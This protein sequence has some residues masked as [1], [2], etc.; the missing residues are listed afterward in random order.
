MTN[1]SKYA[2]KAAFDIMQRLNADAQASNTSVKQSASEI[3]ARINTGSE[4]QDVP[5]RYVNGVKVYDGDSSTPAGSDDEQRWVGGNTPE[6]RT[7]ADGVMNTGSAQPLSIEARDR[8]AELMETGNY[9]NQGDGSKGVWGRD[10]INWVD[11]DGGTISQQLLRE[12]YS[13]PMVG[14]DSKGRGWDNEKAYAESLSEF[15]AVGSTKAMR[16]QRYDYGVIT[17]DPDMEMWD[18]RGFAERAWDRGIDHTQMNLFQ[19]S[20]LMGE[21]TG[22][23]MMTEWGEEG[24]IRNMHEAAMSPA[25]VA[26]SDDIE[27]LTD[28][29]KFI[30]EKTIENAP[31]LLVDLGVGAAS[32]AAVV[33]TGGAASAVLAPALLASI[34]KS[35]IGKIGWKA[36]GKFGVQSAMF[37][38]MAGEARHGQLAEGVDNPMLAL[39][40]GAVNTTLEF[41]GMQSMLQGFMP[42]GKITNAASLAKHIAQRAAIS[43]GVEG[44]TE[45]LQDLNN[46]IAIKLSKPDYTI[47]WKQL[48]ESFFAGMAAGGGMGTV[49]GTAG[50]SYGL[51]KTI[52]ENVQTRRAMDGTTPEAPVQIQAQLANITDPNTSLDAVYAADPE[53]ADKVTLPE[54]VIAYNHESGVLFTTNEAKGK[55]FEQDGNKDAKATLGYLETKEEVMANTKVEDLRSVVA[56]DVDG[57]AVGT[58]MTSVANAPNVEAS[59]VERYGDKVTISTL[60]GP[61][62]TE[63]LS[64]RQELFNEDIRV[65]AE[66]RKGLN[67]DGGQVNTNEAAAKPLEVPANKKGKPAEGKGSK[68]MR[69]DAGKLRPLGD[70]IQEAING[71]ISQE[72]I[73]AEAKKA[74]V[75]SRPTTKGAFPRQR[76]INAIISAEKTKRDDS[77]QKAAY[78]QTQ[79]E[80]SDLEAASNDALA[81]M[82]E[83]RGV[84]I[85]PENPIESGEKGPAFRVASALIGKMNNTKGSFIG[86]SW[87]KLDFL[88]DAGTDT[89]K[90]K[91]E[92]SGLY[93]QRLLGAVKV[94]A[95]QSMAE[96]IAEGLSTLSDYQ[97]S[98]LANEFYLNKVNRDTGKIIETTREDDIRQLLADIS[99]RESKPAKQQAKVEETTTSKVR[100]A[101]NRRNNKRPESGPKEQSQKQRAATNWETLHNTVRLLM[102]EQ[103]PKD[104]D[105]SMDGLLQVLIGMNWDSKLVRDE[106][107]AQ[108]TEL[109]RFYETNNLNDYVMGKGEKFSTRVDKLIKMTNSHKAPNLRKAVNHPD[110]KR[111]FD[112]LSLVF[113]T[114]QE[115]AANK[116]AAGA[117]KITLGKL[118]LRGRIDLTLI[119]DALSKQKGFRRKAFAEAYVDRF[120]LDNATAV[121]TALDIL[122][123]DSV[124]SAEKLFEMLKSDMANAKGKAN[125]NFPSMMVNTPMMK[126]HVDSIMQ[127]YNPETRHGMSFVEDIRRIFAYSEGD[128]AKTIAAMTTSKYINREDRSYYDLA[129][130]EENHSRPVSANASGTSPIIET[131]SQERSSI[132]QFFHTMYRA[133]MRF[134]EVFTDVNTPFVV[135]DEGVDA[136]LAKFKAL[137]PNGSE[138]LAGKRI[139]TVD[140]ETFFNTKTGYSLGNPDLSTEAYIT[141]PQFEI[142]GLAVKEGDTTQ[143][144][145]TDEEIAALVVGWKKDPNVTLVMHNARFDAAIFKEKFGYTPNH[146]IDTLRL[147]KGIRFEKDARH[148]LDILSEWMFPDNKDLQKITGGTKNVDGMTKEAIAASAKISAQFEEYAI[149]D[150]DS[151]QAIALKLAPLVQADELSHQ[152]AGIINDVTGQVVGTQAERMHN[153]IF[154]DSGKVGIIEAKLFYA[155]SV[156]NDGANLLEVQLEANGQSAKTVMLD[157]IA[158]AS[159]SDQSTVSSVSGALEVLLGN[160][161]R[162][163]VGSQPRLKADLGRTESNDLQRQYTLPRVIP[164]SLVIFQEADGTFK[165]VGDARKANSLQQNEA[166]KSS[167]VYNF[168]ENAQVLLEDKRYQMEALVKTL[169][170]EG[171]EESEIAGLYVKD[172]MNDVHR[173][174]RKEQD[175]GGLNANPIPVLP[176][177]PRKANFNQAESKSPHISIYEMIQDKSAELV[178]L[179][180]RLKEKNPTYD[181]KGSA[182]KI[183][184]G[185][186]LSG[187]NEAIKKITSERQFLRDNLRRLTQT[188]YLADYVE[189]HSEI[190]A[191]STKEEKKEIQDELSAAIEQAGGKN[192]ID[193]TIGLFKQLKEAHAGNLRRDKDKSPT[194]G[195]DTGTKLMNKEAGDI[196]GDTEQSNRSGLVLDADSRFEKLK[197]L[198][199]IIYDDEG[200]QTEVLQ[201][202]SDDQARIAADNQMGNGWMNN[203]DPVYEFAAV[204]TS[205]NP[206]DGYVVTPDTTSS[207]ELYNDQDEARRTGVQTLYPRTKGEGNDASYAAVETADTSYRV[208]GPQWTDSNLMAKEGQGLPSTR[209]GPTTQGKANVATARKALLRRYFTKG[210]KTFGNLAA[211]QTTVANLLNAVGIKQNVAITDTSNAA[212]MIKDLAKSGVLTAKEAKNLRARLKASIDNKQ[213]AYVNMGE[214][215]IIMMPTSLTNTNA[216]NMSAQTYSMVAHEVGHLVYDFSWANA[217]A[218]NKASILSEF[219]ADRQNYSEASD[220]AAFKEWYADQVA[221]SLTQGVLRNKAY[222]TEEDGLNRAKRNRGDLLNVASH[223]RELVKKMKTL[224][225]VLTKA[226]RSPFNETFS[227]YL[228]GVILRSDVSAQAAPETKGEVLNMAKFRTKKEGVEH[229]KFVKLGH[230]IL[231]NV[232]SNFKRLDNNLS[233]LLFQQAST[234]GSRTGEKSYENFNMELTQRYESLYSA[235]MKKIGKPKAVRQAFDDLNNN[236]VTEHS[237]ILRKMMNDINNDLVGY[238]PTYQVR[239]DMIPQA[240]DHHQVDGK[241]EAFKAMLMQYEVFKQMGDAEMNSRIA[242]LLDGQ[243]FNERTIAPGKP[244]G[245]HAFADSILSAVPYADLKEYLV[246][247][248]D[249]IMSHYIA[250]AA[251][252]ASWEHTFGGYVIQDDL[253]KVARPFGGQW[254]NSTESINTPVGPL[255]VGKWEEG[256]GRKVWSPNKRWHEAMVRIEKKH[257]KAGVDEA[258]TLLDGVMGRTGTSMNSKLRKSQDTLLN[259]VNMNILANS[260]VASVPELGMA[261]A[262]AANLLSVKDMFKGLNLREARRIGMDIGTVLS[263]GLAQIQGNAANEAYNG[264][265]TQKMASKYFILNG[266]QE[267]TK[268]SRTFS[269]ALGMRYIEKAADFNQLEELNAFHVT[270]RQVKT[271]RALGKPAFTE[272]LSK[273]EA[274]SVRAV[275]GAIMQFVT[276]SSFR[277]SRFQNP[278]WGNNPYMKIAFHLK[279]FLYAI[280]DILVLGLLRQAKRRFSDARGEGM[281]AAGAYAM[282]PIVVGGIAIAALTM[283]AIELRELLKGVDKTENMGDTK[284][285]MEVFSKSGTLGAF[286]MGYNVMN[287]E[288]WDDKLGRLVPTFGFSQG[289]FESATGKDST[290]ETIRHVT[291]F[292][293]QYKNWWPGD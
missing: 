258:L 109:K 116:E 19:F 48:T 191:G 187:I 146:M 286:E 257:G 121:F 115:D 159:Y 58:E 1:L 46:Q 214:F 25:D 20:E 210:V 269:T 227:Q 263:N 204:K 89:K 167:A 53:A 124:H 67:P 197:F 293:S 65:R 252:R 183:T 155:R 134:R 83:E 90:G 15:D 11:K 110:N 157:A 70:L 143:Y 201:D 219:A 198:P 250:S 91:K 248:P 280:T 272:G 102:E 217:S 63:L 122:S 141:D 95:G 69:D 117:A 96:T 43:T 55:A 104:S 283:F 223:F 31:N 30:V 107:V 156:A 45:F 118:L 236:N 238:M 189:Q 281:L 180:Q 6:L 270:A 174:T 185:A 60:D 216:A 235:A 68:S 84:S 245:A 255:T 44:G 165:T 261:V 64:E 240:F 94:K 228:D 279:Q 218:K 80:R 158:I 256:K 135:A 85:A 266:Q 164:D 108:L 9:Q 168:L 138:Y 142:L 136:R 73:V 81:Q 86:S 161:S 40:I 254:A 79:S 171:S 28:L 271:W 285:A 130:A 23:D 172:L 49:S 253:T 132:N 162:M 97:L 290:L 200:N 225:T 8:A 150:V 125:P 57:V 247:E 114:R 226:V 12:G 111:F 77:G 213:A 99:E 128:A 137:K 140:F 34:G 21:V 166:N 126:R 10:L 232:S 59:M 129:L 268:A 209:F 152:S 205:K 267:I 190:G 196:L 208:Y 52:G 193:E 224:W 100:S 82:A 199:D 4:G 184:D 74:G 119:S 72:E 51:M 195:E 160:L 178:S 36:A 237:L 39:G 14:F 3:M 154:G 222:I 242:Y 273:I 181:T 41:R 170:E 239:N 42:K 176:N 93:G 105:R 71:D 244:V 47:D 17:P 251:K 144:I 153:G 61:Q 292:F 221:L 173:N 194:S 78:S 27:S 175:T 18:R 56:R 2:E 274:D 206:F 211:V 284:Y 289:V 149:R 249:A 62:T 32:A 120:M 106:I 133:T 66:E 230:R 276:E 50:G 262:R 234:T 275:N 38:Q 87:E 212:T 123:R 54:G 5:D 233:A 277:P 264:T 179:S 33:A 151:T 202:E 231:G 88:F 203:D 98:E 131:V 288:N 265:I 278:S 287:A 182:K 147:S 113:N 92:S 148:S 16:E 112:M 246:M 76:I 169:K 163:A 282:V 177:T 13:A 37:G 103:L 7:N 291:P 215:A 259:V 188:G 260:G 24:V 127:M 139:I 229:N 243:G 75:D 26:T 22:S 192:L 186:F 101:V 220:S 145:Q 207:T 29:G 35:F 241:R